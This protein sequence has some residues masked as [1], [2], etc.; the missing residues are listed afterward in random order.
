MSIGTFEANIVVSEFSPYVTLKTNLHEIFVPSW[1]L[2]NRLY[3]SLAGTEVTRLGKR[4]FDIRLNGGDVL[5][6]GEHFREKPRE[7][8]SI[9]LWVKL[10]RTGGV[11]SMFDTIGGH[12]IHSKGQYHFEVYNGRLRWFHR[13]EY[14]KE[15]FNVRTSPVLQPNLWYHVVGTYDS[16]THMVRVFVNGDLVGEGHGSGMLSLDW[17]AK[18]GFGSHSGRRILLGY[19]DEIYIFRRALLEK[20][21]DRYLEN[22]NRDS[23]LQPDSDGTYT[24]SYT[25]DPSEDDSFSDINTD[26]VWFSRPTNRLT[27]YPLPRVSNNTTT[28][29]DQ[30]QKPT[31]VVSAERAKPTQGQATQTP[32]VKSPQTTETTT[33]ST[34]PP[35]TLKATTTIKTTAMPS[36]VTSTAKENFNSICR[37]GNVYRNRDLVGGLG[38]GNFTDKG[39]VDTIE[40]CMKICCG[41]PDCSVAYMVETNCFAI[42]CKEKEQCKTFMKD[43][44]ENSP[45]IGFVDRNRPEG[46][47]SYTWLLSVKTLY[48]CTDPLMRFL[49]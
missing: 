5:L 21:I 31:A 29:M 13:N 1:N 24:E 36:K 40:Q 28:Y 25:D 22:P 35:T 2:S 34:T 18:A 15:V 46:K 23:L 42:T 6:D 11:H 14:A 26:T 45:V 3:R 10:W 4:G 44:S 37:L 49:P 27:N 7:A 43:P 41:V 16:R 38:A 8:V 47:R 30:E 48:R 33:Q 20:E 32:T 19:L 17:E 12:S 9:A 39:T